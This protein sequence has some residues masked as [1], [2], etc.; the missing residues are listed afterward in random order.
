M[1]GFDTPLALVG[2]SLAVQVAATER[3]RRG[4][5]TLVINP[6]GPWG[7]YFAGVKAGG[8]LWDAGMVA[9]EFTSFR[10]PGIPPAIASYDPMRRNDIGRFTHAVRSYVE[11]H[12]P[13]RAIRPLQMWLDD[14]LLPDLLL[15]NA[16]EALSQLGCKQGVREELRSHLSTALASPWHAQRKDL[17]PHVDV[18]DYDT[19]SRINHGN[20]LHDAVIAPFA[21]KVLGRDAGHLHALFHRI[22]W[23]PLYW[24]Q[25][26]LAALDEVPTNLPTTVY[27]HPVGAPVAQ[28]CAQLASKMATSSALTVRHER[29]I[30]VERSAQGFVLHLEQSGKLHAARLGW[31]PTP[32]QGLQACGIDPGTPPEPRLPLML[33]FLR[34]AR[35]ALL[36]EFS[37]LHAPSSDTALYRVVNATDCAGLGDEETVEIVAEANLQ[38]FTTHHGS[39]VDDPA[40][41]RAVIADLHRLGVVT[42]GYA[43]LFSHVMRLPSALPLPTPEGLRTWALERDL[44]LERLPGLEPLANSSGPFATSLSDQ[45]VQGLQLAQRADVQP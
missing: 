3:A 31:S 16:L 2:N 19:V 21:R 26:L 37:V 32:L 25:T 39:A 12:L 44:L 1:K 33:V 5:P 4:L 11:E 35:H 38:V 43:P 41:T 29:V 23:L 14:R 24:P 40:T 36:R 13:T 17:W 34:V 28:L 15:G 27:S 18:P 8:T 45:I 10:T 20:V 7:G 6:G 42:E 9:F 30:G 22:P